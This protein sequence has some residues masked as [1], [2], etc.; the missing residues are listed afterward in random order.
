MRFA[1]RLGGDAASRQPTRPT[2]PLNKALLGVL[3]EA[4]ARSAL[5]RKLRSARHNEFRTASD[6]SPTHPIALIDDLFR[7][8]RPAVR[9]YDRAMSHRV[10]KRTTMNWKPFGR[11][12]WACAC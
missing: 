5:L 6:R 12:S 2:G 10:N 8:Y 11:A 4:S 1:R 7:I 9:W 3:C